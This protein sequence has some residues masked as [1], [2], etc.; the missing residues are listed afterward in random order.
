MCPN[1][2]SQ[3]KVDSDSETVFCANC[4]IQLQAR[5]AFV[6]YD[7]KSG[8]NVDIDGIGSYSLLL[9]CGAGFFERGEYDKSDACFENMLKLAPDDY[10]VW[11]LRAKTW[12]AKVVNELKNSFYTY[13]KKGGL[14]ENKEYLTRYKELCDNA[15]RHSPSGTAD[16][17]AEEFNDRIREHFELAHRAYRNDR[18]KSASFSALAAAALITLIAVAL[19][20]CR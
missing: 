1:C 18:R 17:L 11:K 6:Y 4:G 20:S 13:S 14:K 19:H 12:E 2:E 10:Q 9:K 16:E 3:L 7:L 8:G 5:D 15:V